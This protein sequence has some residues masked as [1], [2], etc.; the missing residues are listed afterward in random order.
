MT[1]ALLTVEDLHTYYGESHI[2][3]GVSVEIRPSQVVAILGRNGAGKTTTLRSIMRITLPRSGRVVFDGRSLDRLRTFE[4]AQAGIA[5][6]Q[7]TRA[8]FPSLTVA[9]NLAIAARPGPVGRGWGVDRVFD[10]FPVL[11]ARRQTDG[12]RLS[13]GEQQMLAITRALVANPRLILLDE[14]SEGLAPLIRREI[15]ALLTQ[16]KAEGMAMLLVEQD[17][18][19]ATRLADHVLVLGRGRIQ[20]QGSSAALDAAEDVKRAWLG[21]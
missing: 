11:R 15:R 17:Y 2:L 18:A 1:E 13:G 16:L 20:W 12:T 19:L 4:I 8:I 3:Q 6:V 14:P 10:R 9:E 5:F 7:E 21:V